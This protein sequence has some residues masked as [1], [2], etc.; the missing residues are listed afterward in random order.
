MLKE[1][2]LSWI[3]TNQDKFIEISNKIW[4]Y[5]ETGLQEYQSSKLLASTLEKEGFDV[6]TGVAEMPTA[7]MASYG[8]GKPIIAILGEFDAL[9]GLSQKPQPIKEPIKKDANGHGCGHNH[10]GTAGL[11]ASIA[12]KNLIADG[13]L[14]GTIRYYG[15]PA[16]EMFNAKGYMV[17]AGLFKDVDIGLTWHPSSLNAVA[18]FSTNAVID[19]YFNFYGRA[20]H[21]AGDPENGRSALDAVELMNVGCNYLREHM[22]TS[23]RLHYTI[24][25]GGGAPN[26]VPAEAE[27]WYFVRAPKYDEAK[28]LFER[29]VKVAKGAA[30]MTETEVKVD[31]VSGTYNTSENSVIREAIYKNM[32][33]IGPQKWDEKD[34]EFARE[35]RKSIPEGAMNTWLKLVPKEFKAQAE[36]LFKKP[37]CDVILPPIGD[38]S[39]MAGST[40]VADVSWVLPLAQF[41][42][43]TEVMGS[44]GHS[45]QNVATGRTMIGHKGMLLAAKVLATTS[46]DFMQ[47]EELVK[48]AWEEFNETHKT[49]KY[50]SP[51]P[52]DYKL[53]FHRLKKD[54]LQY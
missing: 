5:A 20:S 54:K 42:T 12:I 6:K 30:M 10:L 13:K 11:A 49:E 3:D 41:V 43:A 8:T 17:R 16:E 26:V 44:P 39:T 32:V 18:N 52:D 51:F 25:N 2:V 34:L 15:A 27:V 1:E 31:F 28:K 53:P 19:V 36:E 24:T 46:I 22:S 48:K 33:D 21:A 7:I 4:D 37:L 38:G 29:V 9:P 50:V 14:S 35:L 40:D 47:N 45:W 23:S